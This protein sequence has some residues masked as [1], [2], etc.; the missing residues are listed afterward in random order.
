[1][2]YYS[3]EI[4]IKSTK[5]RVYGQSS[6][7]FPVILPSGPMGIHKFSWWWSMAIYT[8]H[9]QPGKLTWA[10]VFRVCA[11]VWSSRYGWQC[12]QLH[13]DFSLQPLQRSSWY[14]ITQSPHHKSHYLKTCQGLS[15]HLPEAEA[16]RQASVSFWPRLSYSKMIIFVWA[17]T[18]SVALI[19]QIQ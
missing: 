18:F 13:A 19:S 15:D 11:G 10:S 17:S 3:E 2:V 4:Q 5:G 8:V 9:C 1:M 7:E 12:D 16:K 14:H 6:G